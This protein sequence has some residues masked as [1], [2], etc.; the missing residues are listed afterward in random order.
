MTRASSDLGQQKVIEVCEG[1]GVAAL[2]GKLLA[3]LGCAVTKLEPPTGDSLR[4]DEAGGDLSLFSLVAGS[5]DSVCLD[6]DHAE[7]PRLLRRLLAQA[8]ILVV[9]QDSWDRM[10]DLVGGSLHDGAPRLTVCVC[11]AFGL[12]GPMA[13]WRGGEDIVQAMSGIAS[14][15]SHL[16]GRPTR[17]ASQTVTHTTALHAVSAVLGD[18]LLKRQSGRGALLEA[19]MFDTAISLLT[20]AMPA[21]F[22]ERV[23]PR[24]IGN[25][26]TMAAP[27]NSFR[28]ADG[29]AIVCAGNDPTWN[30]LCEAVGRREL[31]TDPLYATQESRVRN[32]DKLEAEITAWTAQRSVE[33]VEA[34]MDEQGIPC[35]SIL[36]LEQVLHHPQFAD[37]GLLRDDGSLK[38][39][40]GVFHRNRAPLP[41]TA[42]ASDLGGGAHL[43]GPRFGLGAAEL[44][45]LLADGVI[46]DPKEDVDATAA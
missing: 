32:V 35:G 36:S 42:A 13:S 41:V 27:W 37:R 22:L 45:R 30:R 2:T 18:V 40:G 20:A 23:A 4:R 8:D 33:Q 16:D 3:D 29:W 26:H 15:T 14:T 19:C 9:D 43:L 7:A 31:L 46:V 10:R 1:F 21:Y 5:K 44:A 24:G 34:I 17:I 28:C 38:I 12:E 11:T 25:R 6:F 39:A